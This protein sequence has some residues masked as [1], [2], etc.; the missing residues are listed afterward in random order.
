MQAF[1]RLPGMRAGVFVA[2]QGSVCSTPLASYQSPDDRTGVPVWDFETLIDGSVEVRCRDAA[3]WTVRIATHLSEIDCGRSRPRWRAVMDELSQDG[4]VAIIGMAGRFP[5]A[6]NI[7]RFWEMLRDGREAVTFYS[8]DELLQAGVAR[9]ELDDA[10]YVKAAP[11]LEDAVHFDREYFGY[12][13][14]EAELIDPQ[15]RIFLECCVEALEN[16]ACDPE[17]FDG[18]IGVFGGCA[19]N[20]YQYALV[21]KS[22]RRPAFLE[23]FAG[24]VY[25]RQRQGLSYDKGILQAQLA[26][27]QRCGPDSMFHVARSRTFCAAKHPLRGMRRCAGWGRVNHPQLRKGR[28]WVC[29]RRNLFSRRPYPPIRFTCKRHCFR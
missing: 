25:A 12:S 5:G 4:S 17:R 3:N 23:L 15:Q 22:S 26:R 24:H 8:D 1:C 28:L 7:D 18:S 13:P 19:L 16:A 20:V 27:A 11:R 14:R 9:A 29:R 6:P 2:S 10:H 21:E